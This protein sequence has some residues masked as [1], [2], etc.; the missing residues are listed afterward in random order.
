MTHHRQN[1]RSHI[2]LA[3]VFQLRDESLET[4]EKIPYIIMGNC[5]QEMFK[6]QLADERI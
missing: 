1:L 3:T 5:C 4:H 6:N 2:H